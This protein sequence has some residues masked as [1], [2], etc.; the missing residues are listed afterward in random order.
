MWRFQALARPRERNCSPFGPSERAQSWVCAAHDSVLGSRGCRPSFTPR[1]PRP[2]SRGTATFLVAAVKS[3]LL[4]LCNSTLA[5][6]FDL[7]KE[8]TCP[9]QDLTVPYTQT[10]Q[11]EP[12]AKFTSS[13]PWRAARAAYPQP[14]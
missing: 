2:G 7:Y 14:S 11:A 9:Y 12:D 4:H 5:C 13:F 8:R 1:I 10:R 6:F 3:E